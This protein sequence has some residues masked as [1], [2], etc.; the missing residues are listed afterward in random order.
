[1]TTRQYKKHKNLKKENLRDNMTNLEL[2][3]NM[4]SEA[5]ATELS[6]KSIPK[7]LQESAVVAQKGANVAKNA[8]LEIEQQGGNVISKQNAKQLG[9]R[10]SNKPQ[11]P[12]RKRNNDAPIME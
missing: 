8:R 3:I 11:I 4:L 6:V 5:S 1:M 9:L 10:Q 12:A 2:I 7:N